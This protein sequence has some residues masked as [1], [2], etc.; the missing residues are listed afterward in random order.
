MIS[1]DENWIQICE[2][3]KE[4]EI[5]FTKE[6]LDLTSEI[7]YGAR[8]F[9]AHLITHWNEEFQTILDYFGSDDSENDKFSGIDGEPMDVREDI[10]DLWE[11]YGKPYEGLEAEWYRDI[12]RSKLVTIK[13]PERLIKN[14][15][16]IVNKVIKG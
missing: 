9:A 11:Y 5:K 15:V 2:F 10:T 12:L 16:K 1:I 13:L 3:N 8:R 4:G 14:Y 7:G 6:Y